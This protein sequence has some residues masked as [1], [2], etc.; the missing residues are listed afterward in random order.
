ME[1][2]ARWEKIVVQWMSNKLF[3]FDDEENLIPS[4]VKDTWDIVDLV[5]LLLDKGVIPDFICED[6]DLFNVD[7]TNGKIGD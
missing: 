1:N 2:A 3:V 7:A 4:K 5:K 6:A